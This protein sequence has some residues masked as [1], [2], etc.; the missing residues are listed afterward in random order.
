MFRREARRAPYLQTK[1][2]LL[3]LDGPYPGAVALLTSRLLREDPGQQTSSLSTCWHRMVKIN[4]TKG[5]RVSN[6]DR[7][8]SGRATGPIRTPRAQRQS[9]PWASC[10]AVAVIDRSPPCEAC[11]ALLA[12][13]R[14]NVTKARNAGE[15]VYTTSL[16][17]ASSS[18]VDPKSRILSRFRRRGCSPT[19]GSAPD[20]HGRRD[21]HDRRPA[22]L[23]NM[24]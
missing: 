17:M 18:W 6:R 12:I 23:A 7:L 24:P 14:I 13:A 5:P 15:V 4:V 10:E 22:F 21:S 2:N 19:S 20:K 3:A 16:S 8:C 9:V 11:C 1:Y